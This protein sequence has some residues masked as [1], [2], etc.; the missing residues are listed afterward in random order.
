[1]RQKKD[2]QMIKVLESAYTKLDSEGELYLRE[3]EGVGAAPAGGDAGARPA[4]A[5]AGGVT[6]DQVLGPSGG[7][8]KGEGCMGKGDFHV[9]FPIMPVLFRYPTRKSRRKKKGKNGIRVVPSAKNPYVKGMTTVVAES[10]KEITEYSGP[11]GDVFSEVTESA[12]FVCAGVFGYN[13]GANVGWVVGDD[14]VLTAYRPFADGGIWKIRSARLLESGDFDIAESYG[15]YSS[16]S[17]AGR[18]MEAVAENHVRE[19]AKRMGGNTKI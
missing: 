12:P 8:E 3:C 9:P 1:M 19:L 16:P 5:P 7:A 13:H 10:E 11:A 14:G 4:P 2:I 17:D 6:T 18:A 15:R